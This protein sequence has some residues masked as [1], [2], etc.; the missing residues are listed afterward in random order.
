[1][2]YE[3]SMKTIVTEIIWIMDMVNWCVINACL[4]LN[5]FKWFWDEMESVLEL[6]TELEWASVFKMNKSRD[7][8]T[9]VMLDIGISC[10]NDKYVW[11]CNLGYVN[12][13]KSN[14]VVNW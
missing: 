13:R 8:W 1:M 5:C 10:V 14:K 11:A 7:A 3:T 9:N 2:N 12:I 6:E 4:R